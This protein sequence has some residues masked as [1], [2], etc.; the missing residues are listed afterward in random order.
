MPDA[1]TIRLSR[2]IRAAVAS[3]D[4]TD[5]VSLEF[6]G[7]HRGAP[8]QT[9]RLTGRVLMLT[10]G[11]QEIL[12]IA[13]DL[14]ELYQP[15][16]ERFKRALW[17]YLNVP[18]AN[19]IVWCNH[20]HAAGNSDGVAEVPLADRLAW[21][22]GQAREH[23]TPVEWA[24]AGKDLGPGW[25]IRRRFAIDD[26][27]TFC[28]MFNDD[29]RVEGER[30][31][32]SGQVL[33]YLRDR[34]VDPAV[35]SGNGRRAYCEPPA[36]TRLELLSLRRRDDRRPLASILRF[37]AHP[38]IASHSK[39]GNALCPDYVGSLRSTFERQFGSTAIFLQGPCADVRP[40]HEQYGVEAADAY[41][42]RLA[43]QAATL[44]RS[45]RYRPVRRA[46]IAR[47][48]ASVRLRP[49]YQW[50]LER[51]A[52]EWERTAR[53]FAAEKAPARRL[54]L[55]RRIEA[56]QWVEFHQ[57]KRPTIIPPAVLKSGTWP[58][59]VSAVRLGGATL[60]NLPGEIFAATGKAVRQALAGR[61]VR[62]PVIITELAGPYANYVS[63]TDEYG[64]GGYEDTCCF[65]DEKAEPAL[66]RAAIKAARAARSDGNE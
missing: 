12:L 14:L 55:R 44:V 13:L 19:M 25:T 62:E 54:A 21:G 6:R 61:A 36:D 46:G 16:M 45:L 18:P 50:S 41:G 27:E 22:I 10:E 48:F 47:Q 23:Y 63:P 43:D 34:G 30:L 8:A 60:V 5:L 59:E 40:L 15:W 39:I 11:Q 56:L 9:G 42:R 7:K 65:L 49:E 57:V 2:P 4:I 52:K 20:I 24:Y 35:W 51:V 28:V 1:S 33:A 53:K 37:A 31:E 26:L 64:S 29:C 3:V 58:M 38:T 66:K 32:V 17:S